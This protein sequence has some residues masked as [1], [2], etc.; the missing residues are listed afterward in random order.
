[1]PRQDR[2]LPSGGK[3]VSPDGYRAQIR[4]SIRIG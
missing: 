1:M 2:L 4:Q 3:P